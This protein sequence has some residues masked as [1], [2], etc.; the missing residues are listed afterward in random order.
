MDLPRITNA[1]RELP[2]GGA[3]FRARALTL[4]DLGEVLAWLEARL[5]PDLTRDGPPLFLAEASRLALATTEGL[6]VVLHLSLLSCQPS[7][8]RG[9]ARRLAAAMTPEG[10]SRLWA[11]AFRRRTRHEPRGE[12]A[13]ATDLAEAPWGEIVEALTRRRAWAYPLVGRLT[14]DQYDNHAARGATRG[15]DDLGP[16]DVQRMWEAAMAP[17][18][19]Q[20]DVTPEVLS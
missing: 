8:T 17:D 9:D 3:V 15:R 5:P 16:A 6:A 14:L 7:L 1:P 20:T 13:P 11:I 2:L 19:D 4:A 10:E 12:G 18:A